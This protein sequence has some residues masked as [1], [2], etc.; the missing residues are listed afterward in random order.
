MKFKTD[1]EPVYTEDPMYDLF[2]GG[3]IKPEELL[4]SQLEA[5]KVRDAMNIVEQFLDEGKEAGKIEVG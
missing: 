2:D 5:R 1:I 3:Y 4:E